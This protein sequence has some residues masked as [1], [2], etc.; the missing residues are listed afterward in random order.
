MWHIVEGWDVPRRWKIQR[1]KIESNLSLNVEG[2]AAADEQLHL[3]TRREDLRQGRSGV[4]YVLEVIDDE[5][6]VLR[7]QVIDELLFD[8]LRV[9]W[10]NSE[11]LSQY[12]RHEG[13]VPNRSQRHEDGS[14]G[15]L[16][17]HHLGRR[18][19]QARLTDPRRSDHRYQTRSRLAQQVRYAADFDVTADKRGWWN[20]KVYLVAILAR[21]ATTF[22][23]VLEILD[24]NFQRV[25]KQFDRMAVR[26]C[27]DTTLQV[28]NGADAQA[29]SL[30][31]LFLSQAGGETIVA[32]EASEG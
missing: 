32:Q 22:N 6:D 8:G 15:K 19:R 17:R 28:A 21:P 24:W 14:I 7:P 4:Q 13:G 30:R 31:Q 1:S 23:R 11:R 10:L 20:G 18:E 2:G 27:L 12:L 26:Q 9:D 5:Q 29:C 16:L 3:G 25:R